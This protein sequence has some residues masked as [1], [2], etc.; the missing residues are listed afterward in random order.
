MTNDEIIEEPVTCCCGQLYRVL[1]DGTKEDVDVF[2]DHGAIVSITP[3]DTE[4]ECD[5]GRPVP[6]TRWEKTSALGH[7]WSGGRRRAP[8]V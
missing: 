4:H 8:E 1:P 3:M 7:T 5:E 6:V 2:Y